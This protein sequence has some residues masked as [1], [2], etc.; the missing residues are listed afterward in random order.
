MTAKCA[1]LCMQ[2]RSYR[3]LASAC[4]P[5]GH[6]EA[7]RA[8]SS[9]SPTDLVRHLGTESAADSP[10]APQEH[11][12]SP[13]TELWKSR[14]VSAVV[15]R[16]RQRVA[17]LNMGRMAALLSSG[18]GGY[19]STRDSVDA[20][21][22]A[23]DA[24]AAT[25]PQETQRLGSDCELV[26]P[27]TLL[28]VCC[29][30]ALGHLPCGRSAAHTARRRPPARRRDG[31][32]ILVAAVATT[33]SERRAR[34]RAGGGVNLQKFSPPPPPP[35]HLSLSSSSPAASPTL[36]PAGGPHEELTY[37]IGAVN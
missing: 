2:F 26:C 30:R 10:T 20:G 27:L 8:P 13:S 3:A 21:L 12:L 9:C 19:T 34:R 5:H 33:Q 35:T 7:A 29:R 32:R 17:A 23:L 24:T 11:R 31:R 14:P 25:R 37:S 16:A 1:Y 22:H 28:F 15:C 36:G 4:P 18:A 6:R